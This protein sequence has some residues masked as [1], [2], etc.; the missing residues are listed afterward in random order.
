MPHNPDLTIF[1]SYYV[2]GQDLPRR[3]KVVLGRNGHFMDARLF[4]R[5]LARDGRRL[6][7]FGG[8]L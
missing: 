8:P 4:G 5:E 3:T 2:D 7:G 1:G 6:A